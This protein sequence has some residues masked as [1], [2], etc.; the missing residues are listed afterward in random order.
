MK[1]REAWDAWREARPSILRLAR[2]FDGVN[3]VDYGYLYKAGVRTRR[4]GVRFHVQSKRPLPEVVPTQMLPTSINGLQCDVLQ[5]SF[6]LCSSPQK[7][8]DPLRLGVSVG[9]LSRG[10]TGTLGLMVRDQLSGRPAILSNWHVLCG[11]TQARIGDVLVQP[12]PQHMG[13]S[14]P[15]TVAR[16]ERWLPLSTGFDAAIGVLDAEIQWEQQLFD[17]V[18]AIKGVAT[19]KRGMAL[20]KF[21]AMSDRT[22]GLV[23]G[24]DGAY[25]IDY[26][27]RGDAPRSM[28]GIM[29]RQD[30]KFG[31]PEISL[32]G[33]SGALWV[34]RQ[35]RAVALL[36]AGEDGLGPTAEYALA[37]PVE[38]VLDLLKLEP[39]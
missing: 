7:P 22:H 25:V 6:G 31:N 13:S 3:G 35:G 9:N 11:S 28:D 1:A 36:F 26:S 12:G 2:R 30:P 15:R 8:S 29:L 21:G 39:L 18:V 24:E 4:V 32:E 27:S 19:P 5:A 17:S 14:P 20:T 34:D 16:L 23:D 37:H 10:S 33:D 38:R